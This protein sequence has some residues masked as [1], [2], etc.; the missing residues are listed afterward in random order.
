MIFKCSIPSIQEW[1][2]SGFV[3]YVGQISVASKNMIDE[4]DHVSCILV[5]FLWNYSAVIVKGE[6]KRETIGWAKI[7]GKER[8]ISDLGFIRKYQ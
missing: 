7:S 3:W 5:I 1:A 8:E 6:M 4:S 2:R